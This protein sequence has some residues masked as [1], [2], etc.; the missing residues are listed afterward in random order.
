MLILVG[1]LLLLGTVAVYLV[2]RPSLSQPQANET[3]QA[4]TQVPADLTQVV[5]AAQ[6]LHR[7]DTVSEG[8]LT[9]FPWPAAA[10]PEGAVSKMKELIGLK[11]RTDIL[12]GELVLKSLVVETVAQLAAD[13]SYPA[14]SVPRDQVAI[15]V[16]VN[17]FSGVA[18]A[19]QPGDRVDVFFTLTFVDLDQETQSKLP[20]QTARVVG[21]SQVEGGENVL[22]GGISAGGE[23][24]EVGQ[25]QGDAL[26]A[27]LY[28]VPSEPQRPRLVTQMIVQ[29]A[30]VLHVGPFT[31]ADRLG[32]QAA[33][34]TPEALP[35]GAPTPTPAPG[36]AA[37]PT[38]DIVTLVVPKQD[39]L[40]LNYAIHAF[41]NGSADFTL[42]LRS[43]GDTGQIITESVTLQ[44]L[45]DR[46]DISVP[47]KQ[48]YG[49]E[50]RQDKPQQPAPETPIAP[51]PGS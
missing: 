10:V 48:P 8:A 51:A 44:Y 21:P 28:Q 20:N 15:A 32:P 19:L 43:A 41:W 17:R 14:L 13:G 23:G 6:D 24:S 25:G 50:P 42:V 18:Q 31:E 27:P 12:R 4:A 2:L 29:N 34:P 9:L 49:L 47:A 37:V 7:G 36:A 11:A 38:R 5:V 16:P 3:P 22:S 45:I 1:L 40:V 46:F 35:A 30:M 33:T 39:A 26:G